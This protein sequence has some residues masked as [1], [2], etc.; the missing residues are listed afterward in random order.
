[1]KLTASSNRVSTFSTFSDHF[2]RDNFHRIFESFAR[3]LWRN[4]AFDF[5]LVQLM[6]TARS[7]HDLSNDHLVFDHLTVLITANYSTGNFLRYLDDLIIG[8]DLYRIFHLISLHTLDANEKRKISPVIRSTRFQVKANCTVY[9]HPW[10]I[11][12]SRFSCVFSQFSPVIPSNIYHWRI[13]HCRPFKRSSRVR[14]RIFQHHPTH[15]MLWTLPPACFI[16]RF[17]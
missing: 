16:R 1:M 12:H 7:L 17:T 13:R 5:S 9:F 3:V 4:E 6:I 15:P 11:S 8:F 14:L 2:G 10:S